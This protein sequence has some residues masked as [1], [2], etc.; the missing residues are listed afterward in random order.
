MSWGDS[1]QEITRFLSSLDSR[2]KAEIIGSNFVDEK[3]VEKIDTQKDAATQSQAEI[4]A[5]HDS[6]FFSLSDL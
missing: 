2:I 4:E 5:I 6:R 3:K 1:V